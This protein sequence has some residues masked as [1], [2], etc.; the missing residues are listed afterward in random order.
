MW[1]LIASLLLCH[2]EAYL[3]AK[4]GLVNITQS[5]FIKLWLEDNSSIGRSNTWNDYEEYSKD[6]TEQ[7]LG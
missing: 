1:I 4:L 5:W 3:Q 2:M 7:E 6:H